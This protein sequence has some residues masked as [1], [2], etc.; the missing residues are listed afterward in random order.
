MRKLFW[1]YEGNA[2]SGER[3]R[4]QV[5][6]DLDNTF[7]FNVVEDPM[8]RANLKERR[9]VVYYRIV[10]EWREWN[11]TMLPEI[12]DSSAGNFSGDGLAGHIDA[13]ETRG[14]ADNP[15][16]PKMPEAK[17]HCGA[18]TLFLQPCC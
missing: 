3:R 10:A 8:E 18:G 13:R 6:E 5:S 2:Q 1:R 9:K 15:M 7:L 4:L 17:S 16:P 14:K 12:N 11:V